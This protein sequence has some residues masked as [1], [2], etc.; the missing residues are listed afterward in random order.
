MDL[1][2]N[3]WGRMGGQWGGAER[4]GKWTERGS[5]AVVVGDLRV[6]GKEAIKSNTAKCQT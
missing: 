5:R 1:A 4:R 3:F 6:S 2:N